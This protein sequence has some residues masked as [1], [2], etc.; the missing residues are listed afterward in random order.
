MLQECTTY[1]EFRSLMR[2]SRRTPVVL[3]KHSTRCP[4]SAGAMAD[5]KTFAEEHPEIP[6]W[7]INIVEHR[8]LAR[9][10][11]DDTGIAHQSPQVF[12]FRDE[13]SAWHASHG[14]IT[15]RALISNLSS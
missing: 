5:F 2:D 7:W 9:Q 4:I 1:E 8:E 10:V 6:C 3:L 14:A 13:R 11:A 12:I 15:R